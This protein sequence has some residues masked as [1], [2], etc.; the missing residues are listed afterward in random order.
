MSKETGFAHSFYVSQ[1]WISCRR[2]YAKSKGKM[3]E[4][5][6]E[7]GT[8]VHHKVRLTPQNITDPNVTMN[9]DNLELLCDECHHNEHKRKMDRR[10]A[11]YDDGRV[12]L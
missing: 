7:A 10:W 1:E 5:C 4:R 3:C 2:A 8:Q 12:D 11:V 9:W 6:G